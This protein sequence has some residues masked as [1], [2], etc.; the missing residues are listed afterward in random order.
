MLPVITVPSVRRDVF[1]CFPSS[2]LPPVAP[3]RV[4]VSL[5]RQHNASV[6]QLCVSET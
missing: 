3:V 5:K 4:A 2:N 1:M 6:E